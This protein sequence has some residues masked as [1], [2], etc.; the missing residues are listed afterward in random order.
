MQSSAPVTPTLYRHPHGITAVD[1]EYLY[2]GHA[3]AHLIIDSGRAAFVDV[4]TNASVPYLLAALAELGI[5][6]AAVDYLLLTHVHLDHAGGAGAL[7]RE[8]P[9]ARALLHP[10]G[11]PHMIDPA[12]L[13]AGSRAVYG[14]ERFRRMYGELLPIDPQRVRVVADG[15]HVVLGSR[16]LEL[17]HTPGHA[18]HHYVIVDRAHRSIFSGDTFG[19]SYRALDTARGAF[20]TPAT[21]PTQ[22]DPEQHIASIDRMLAYR[23]ESIYLMHFSR[24]TDIPRLGASLK[25]QIG[26]LAAIARARA[27][28]ADPA[29]GIRSDML[30]L[31]RKL[32]RLHG[33]R[34]SDTELEHALEGDLTLNTQ[35]LIA[36]LARIGEL[37]GADRKARS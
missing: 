10:R 34:L 20:I 13:I 8:L 3:A 24:V 7:M 31:W 2:P 5:A 4:G 22:F 1:V 27:A 32:A 11:A 18:Q 36:W 15:E 23:P 29:S 37:G 33:C 21:V 16:T 19:V 25:E 17:I 6:P 30:A 26:E 28:D 35:G 9:N 12:R 14:E